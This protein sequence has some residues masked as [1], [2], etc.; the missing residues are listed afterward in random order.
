MLDDPNNNVGSINDQ[1]LHTQ[2]IALVDKNGYVRGQ[3]FDG[4]KPDEM[5]MLKADI[6][7]LLNEKTTLK[8]FSNNT[9]SNQ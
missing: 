7:K 2:F 9:F 5:N 3:V 8:T 1:F 6:R 4:L